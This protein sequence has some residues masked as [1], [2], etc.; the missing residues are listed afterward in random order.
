VTAEL[1]GQRLPTIVLNVAQSNGMAVR[2]YRRLGFGIHA[3]FCEGL[4]TRR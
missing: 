2:L 1:L 4:A 3:A